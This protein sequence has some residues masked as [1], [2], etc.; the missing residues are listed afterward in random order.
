VRR[1][2]SSA[3]TAT[4]FTSVLSIGKIQKGIELLPPSRKRRELEAWVEADLYGWF[5]NKLL[6]VTKAISRRW[7]I[8]AARSQE[9]GQPLGNIDG[10][11]AATALEHEL[12]VATHNAKHFAGLGADLFDPWEPAE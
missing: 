11:L 7:G 3:N 4:L 1:W 5:G 2:L 9:S 6:P 8:L 12:T 10:L